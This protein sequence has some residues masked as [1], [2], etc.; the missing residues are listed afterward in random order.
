MSMAM[1]VQS[2]ET[3]ANRFDFALS[4][5]HAMV[6]FV[7]QTMRRCLDQPL[8]L[9]D[10]AAVAG[11]SAFHFHRVFRSVTGI[12]PSEFLTILRLQEAKRL[13][14]TTSM[15]V[16]DI[17]TEVGYAS[18]GTFT[19]RFG[20]LVGT[21]PGRLR[22]FAD[23]AVLPSMAR[24]CES[25]SAGELP[26]HAPAVTGS[27]TAT[28]PV[29][30]PVFVGLYP[31]PSPQGRPLACSMLTSAAPFHIEAVPPG[32]YFLLAA[33]LPWAEDP[34]VPLLAYAGT[35]VGRYPLPLTVQHDGY[36][37]AADVTLRP[38]RMT[39]PPIL[40]S[41]PFFLSRR[42]AEASGAA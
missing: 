32:Q 15:S 28:V 33:S 42:L 11:L 40:S 41:L 27:I 6:E 8:M 4:S 23:T 29:F 22:Q 18:L 24:L 35:L 39:D 31:K 21:S 10:L 17:C 16:I 37:C 5:P 19:A 38:P 25:L 9:D 1:L 12:P 7:I 34:R 14:L 20:R 30:G 13:L 26:S 2:T 3:P 36:Q